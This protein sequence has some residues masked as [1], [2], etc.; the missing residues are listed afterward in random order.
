M[1]A[2]TSG[3]GSSGP[4]ESEVGLGDTVMLSKEAGVRVS[5]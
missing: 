4:T 3:G 5:L 1:G 2:S